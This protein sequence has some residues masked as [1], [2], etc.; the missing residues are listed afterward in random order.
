M[1]AGTRLRKFAEQAIQVERVLN[2]QRITGSPGK[3]VYLLTLADRIAGVAQMDAV[4][5]TGLSKDVVSKS[6][7]AL[8]DAGLL[9][10]VRE[11]SNPR[12]KRLETTDSGKD[13]LRR[14]ESVLSPPPKE[15]EVGDKPGPFQL[16]RG[17]QMNCNGRLVRAWPAGDSSGTVSTSDY[18]IMRSLRSAGHRRSVSVLKRLYPF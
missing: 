14:I 9:T 3:V 11:S 6:V 18:A 2:Q 13:L 8:V 17:S 7:S 4:D 12:S 1:A 10:Q 15:T 16:R 5:E